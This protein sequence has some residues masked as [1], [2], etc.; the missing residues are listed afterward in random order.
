MPIDLLER[1][2]LDAPTRQWCWTLY[3]RLMATSLLVAAT[4]HGQPWSSACEKP[5]Q[6]ELTLN[7][8]I[9]GMFR[10][11]LVPMGN[12]LDV[13]ANDGQTACM[14][15][16]F[17][18]N[19][20]VHAIDPSPHLVNAMRCPYPNMKPA[21]AMMFSH[22]GGFINKTDS[23]YLHKTQTAV[24]STGNVPVMTV[25][26]LF[27]HQAAGFLHIDVE[28]HEP[29]VLVGARK[30]L[31]LKRPIV[32][33]EVF[34][35]GNKWFD[36]YKGHEHIIEKVLKFDYE[37]YMVNEVCGMPRTC[38]NVLAIPRERLRQM[39]N[40]ATLDLAVRAGAITKVKPNQINAT[41]AFYPPPFIAG[42]HDD[43]RFERRM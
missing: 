26:S 23:S 30:T 36:D 25:D 35:G 41:T 2:Y 42:F 32:T 34:L 24:S 18:R 3:F 19:R 22:A 28:G 7:S 11:K 37:A 40:S 6:F 39:R 21:A 5:A 16:C 17:D 27:A 10:E 33:I 43:T 14:L 1:P 29:E 15:A 13:G 12:I 38:R 4:G 20:T 9:Q 31:S 8:I